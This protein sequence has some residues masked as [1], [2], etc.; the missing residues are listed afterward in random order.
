MASRSEF[1]RTEAG[2]RD[3]AG[4]HPSIGPSFHACRHRHVR[5]EL[6]LAMRRSAA[7]PDPLA[8]PGRLARGPAH[9]PGKT[10]LARPSAE[11]RGEPTSPPLSAL[12]QEIAAGGTI[13]RYIHRR[14]RRAE[15]RRS[16]PRP[17]IERMEPG[18]DTA[19]TE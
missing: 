5:A 3:G 18:A 12:A 2:R 4:P 1:V 10:S 7:G 19:S 6:S 16:Q 8:T 11:C 9:W 14:G 17:R 15:L 13:A